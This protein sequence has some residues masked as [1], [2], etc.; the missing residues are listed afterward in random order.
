M[1][2]ELRPAFAL[3]VIMT[4]ITG[5]AYPLGVTG[6]AKVLF[7]WRA[8]GSLIEKNGTVKSSPDGKSIAPVRPYCARA[9]RAAAR[10]EPSIGPRSNQLQ[11]AATTPANAEGRVR[12][13]RLAASEHR[14]WRTA[15]RGIYSTAAGDSRRPE[16]RKKN[17]KK[18]K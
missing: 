17:L 11:P 14:V 15:T 9:C 7:P 8:S 5:L 4:V 12:G 10:S 3:L 2:K 16:R 18:V 13:E 6:L 1:L